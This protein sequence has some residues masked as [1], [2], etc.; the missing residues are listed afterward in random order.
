MLPPLLRF[1]NNDDLLRKKKWRTITG[2]SPPPP[3]QKKKEER[4]ISVTLIFEN[5]AYFYFIRQNIVFW[6]EWY[7]NHWNWLSSFYSMVIF[8]NIVVNFLFSLVT[9]HS[10]IMFFVTSIHCCPEAHWSVQTKQR[11]NLWTAIPA[12]NS[13]RRFKKIR[14]W[15]CFQ[16]WL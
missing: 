3:P 2:V 16:K 7:Q 1:P 6:K 12:V 4:S 10:G 8:Q 15:L 13:S 11:E 9:F 5:I 14:K